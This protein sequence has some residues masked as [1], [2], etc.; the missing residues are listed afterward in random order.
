MS[1]NVAGL[2]IPSEESVKYP[3]VGS[4]VS[5]TMAG[6]YLTM[7]GGSGTGAKELARATT[8]SMVLDGS[9]SN[10]AWLFCPFPMMVIVISIPI[11]IVVVVVNGV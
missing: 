4:E 1:V 6:P 2:V 8:S 5:K 7:K 3:V 10:S 11:I 9:T